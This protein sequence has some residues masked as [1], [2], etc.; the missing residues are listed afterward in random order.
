MSKT[1]KKQS[2][3]IGLLIVVLMGLVGGISWSAYTTHQRVVQFRL[4]QTELQ[5]VT[6]QQKQAQQQIITTKTLSSKEVNEEAQTKAQQLY[7][8]LK[9]NQSSNKRY[10]A[11]KNKNLLVATMTK[12]EG[13][14]SVSYPKDTNVDVNLS[15]MTDYTQVPVNVMLSKDNQVVGELILDYDAYQQVF[16]NYRYLTKDEVSA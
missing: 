10:Q 14:F 13:L 1:D 8:L 5:L 3:L 4:T 2:V 11:I 12:K 15:E 16:T 9:N 7:S 6:K